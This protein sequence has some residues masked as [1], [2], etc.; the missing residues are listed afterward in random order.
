M[1][2]SVDLRN[3]GGQ[4]SK[5]VRW[6]NDRAV[7]EVL[8]SVFC[9]S[10]W[11]AVMRLRD[12]FFLW[13]YFIRCDIV[14]WSFWYIR[15]LYGAAR[16]LFS[17]CLWWIME[18]LLGWFSL[19]FSLDLFFLCMTSQTSCLFAVSVIF[20][21]W[22]SRFLYCWMM[23]LLFCLS[24]VALLWLVFQDMIFCESI[25]LFWVLLEFHFFL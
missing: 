2:G 13:V 10:R 6:F 7:V 24:S 17:S 19:S 25:P 3:K 21:S 22:Q 11:R 16:L 5:W 4:P 15:S 1:C 20:Y 23:E 9:M 12:A 18:F 14:V 8:F